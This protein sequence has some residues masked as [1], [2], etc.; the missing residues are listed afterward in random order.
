MT[1]P[2]VVAGFSAELLPQIAAVFRD[3]GEVEVLSEVRAA[4]DRALRKRCRLMVL[5]ADRVAGLAASD[6]LQTDPRFGACPVCLVSEQGMTGRLAAHLLRPQRA[7]LNL[8][9]PFGEESRQLLVGLL[10]PATD[11]A[12]TPV[13]EPALPPALEV[14]RLRE[15]LSATRDLHKG[16]VER[17]RSLERA[18][19]AQIATMED[20]IRALEVGEARALQN[21]EQLENSRK[22]TIEAA[23]AESMRQRGRIS[24]LEA[25]L[26]RLESQ[27]AAAEERV[28]GE[29]RKIQAL[30]AQLS[31]VRAEAQ[32]NALEADELRS[33]EG[34]LRF[35]LQVARQEQTRQEERR[36][37]A[38]ANRD[39]LQSQLD[40][41]RGALNSAHELGQSLA[42]QVAEL[43]RKL[44]LQVQEKEGQAQAQART[45][46][47]QQELERERTLAVAQVQSLEA[48]KERLQANLSARSEALA[49]AESEVTALHRK[50]SAV[51]ASFERLQQQHDAL[52][53]ELFD[54][55]AAEERLKSRL[56][57]AQSALT[58]ATS[59]GLALSGERDAAQAALQEALLR[60]QAAERERDQLKE[61]LDDN[62]FAPDLPKSLTDTTP[63]PGETFPAAAQPRTPPHADPFTSDL[64]SEITSLRQA[65]ADEQARAAERAEEDEQTLKGLREQLQQMHRAVHHAESAVSG[66][67]RT[68]AVADAELRARL[69]NLA[70]ERD[71]LILERNRLD[72]QL[73]TW[74]AERAELKA[75]LAATREETEAERRKMRAEH[76][77][78]LH[79][80]EAQRD[81][82]IQ[83]AE[84]ARLQAMKD[85]EWF[86][87][88]IAEYRAQQAARWGAE[89]AAHAD[90]RGDTA[91]EPTR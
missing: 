82:A 87:N 86:L 11:G 9:W 28:S 62:L 12:I 40:N 31:Q 26:N 20:R 41:T 78:A 19:E 73:E 35:A 30:E 21:L 83:D 23:S 47:R 55:V 53:E 8:R 79:A 90:A 29:S 32:A 5:P 52:K 42:L 66:Q 76:N 3:W 45:H 63:S 6:R 1:G 84:Q 34:A 33:A 25:Q 72:E 70:A 60:L 75:L 2:I 58:T 61:H 14:R 85:L 54:H 16:E 49:K 50:E 89:G 36:K 74:T 27:L 91:P 77:E 67:A 81:E 80:I 13:E 17:V 15:A 46:G 18:H 4:H 57:E 59:Q 64:A 38:E 51:R 48:E 22:E 43:E 56:A 68:L 88:T 65:L 37:A 69:R 7:R 44:L 71:R 39:A 10:G 24:T